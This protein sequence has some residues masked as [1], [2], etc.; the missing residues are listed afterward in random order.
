MSNILRR[1]DSVLVLYDWLCSTC[2]ESK[3]KYWPIH[4]KV[5]SNNINDNENL[6]LCVIKDISHLQKI[7]NQPIWILSIALLLNFLLH[8]FMCVVISLIMSWWNLHFNK[9]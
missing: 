5:T 4:I 6:P 3:I 8:N 9:I 1:F 7:Q 2:I